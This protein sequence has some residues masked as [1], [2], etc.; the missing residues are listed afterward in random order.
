M[1]IRNDV[2][3]L[4]SISTFKCKACLQ[5]RIHFWILISESNCVH[6]E[7]KLEHQ[8]Q[9]LRN[10]LANVDE[11]YCWILSFCPQ[12][13]GQKPYWSLQKVAN[14]RGSELSR[15]SGFISAR[16]V[17]IVTENS[18]ATPRHPNKSRI[19]RPDNHLQAP[20]GNSTIDALQTNAG[21]NC[22]QSRIVSSTK[23]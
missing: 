14:H 12:A 20:Y 22:E 2:T 9:S 8:M 11:A 7:P 23:W 16:R 10:E 19:C 15:A 3:Q 6:T 4:V 17:R 1:I 13:S 5:Y 18:S 21:L